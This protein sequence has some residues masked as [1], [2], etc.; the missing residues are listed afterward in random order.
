MANSFLPSHKSNPKHIFRVLLLLFVFFAAFFIRAS[1]IELPAAGADEKVYFQDENEDP[2]LTEM[3]SYFYL[4][5]AQEMAVQDTV[6]WSVDRNEDPL[7]GQKTHRNN[8]GDTL[9]L[10]LSV[11]AFILWKYVFSHI[12]VSLTRTAIWM[13]PVLG[14]LAVIPAFCYVRKRTSFPGGLAAGLLVGCA[15]PF[16]IHTHAGFFDTDMVLAVLPLT[17]ILSLIQCLRETGWKQQLGYAA[18]SAG[19]FF[20]LSLFWEGYYLYFLFSA[21]AAAAALLLSLF[22][23]RFMMKAAQR[24]RRAVMLRGVLF[25]LGLSLALLFLFGGKDVLRQVMTSLSNYRT[26]TGSDGSM[27]NALQFTYEMQ[28]QQVLPDDIF[29]DLLKADLNSVAGRIGGLI[30]CLL[31]FAWFPLSLILNHRRTR[32]VSELSQTEGSSELY[33]S[34]QAVRDRVCEKTDSRISLLLELCFLGLW[35]VLGIL[36]AH[37]SIRLAQIPVLPVSVLCG[38]LI[39]RLFSLS[40]QI[41]IM[42]AKN[43]VTVLLSLLLAAA[44]L[45]SCFGAWRSVRKNLPLA[46]DSKCEAMSY[47]RDKTSPDTALAS[48]WDDGY[49]M[50]YQAERR[51]LTDGGTDNGAATWLMARALTT[52]D[53]DLM[54]GILRMLNE[55]GTDALDVLTGSGMNRP[56]AADLLL[57]LLPLKRSAAE[58]VLSEYAFDKKALLNMTHPTDPDP[59]LLVLNSDMLRI[60]RPLGYFGF[61]D[62]GTKAQKETV[63]ILPSSASA[64][65][66]AEETELPMTNSRY[67][68]FLQKDAQGHISAEYSDHEER[69]APCR[70]QVWEKGKKILDEF[71]GDAETDDRLAVIAVKDG[72]RYCAVL[73][74]QNICSS[75]LI[76]LLVCEDRSIPQTQYLNTWYGRENDDSKAQRR[77]NYKSLPSVSV[78]VWEIENSD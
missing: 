75:M 49:Y 40:E 60:R 1:V 63:F 19:A 54:A 27:P 53:P 35:T 6:T 3:D 57:R 24:D 68:V 48:W 71:S 37:R 16:V 58:E 43:A 29:P 62:P 32:P 20:C 31:A 67:A 50:E 56:E 52:D 76:R 74:S 22:I 4:R 38:L 44:V 47:I 18:L 69:N 72:E 9:P 33:F 26:A 25:W 15:I 13:G 11:L 45:P 2:Y 64:V 34:E 46:T 41:R 42:P 28:S 59:L 10:G 77:I 73:C 7:I 12:G 36:L 39:G 5:K 23:P 21:A 17:A 8:G 30:P 14:S 65:I 61:W 51:T 55:S 78:Q 66:N 70:L